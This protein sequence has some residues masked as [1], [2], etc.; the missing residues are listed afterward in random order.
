MFLILLLLYKISKYIRIKFSLEISK[1]IL[2]ISLGPYNMGQIINWCR[3][4]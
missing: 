2:A 4:M 3:S 1:E